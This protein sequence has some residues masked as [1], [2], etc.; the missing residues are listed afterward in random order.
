MTDDRVFTDDAGLGVPT[1]LLT[2]QE[3]PPYPLPLCST[4]LAHD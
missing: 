1:T 3:Y 4:A 2:L